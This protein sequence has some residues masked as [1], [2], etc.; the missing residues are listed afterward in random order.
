VSQAILL[1]GYVVCRAARIRGRSFAETFLTIIAVSALANFALMSAVTVLGLGITAAAPWLIV[2]ELSFIIVDV[3][4][5]RRRPTQRS[6]TAARDEVTGQP[7]PMLVALVIAGA[8]CAAIMLLV[9]LRRYGAVFSEWD[10][11]FSWNEWAL[12]WWSGR[13]PDITWMYPQLVPTNWSF[14]YAILGSTEL[15]SLPMAM[16]GLYPA[17]SVLMLLETAARRRLPTYAI[18]AA[19]FGVL[20]LLG[21]RGNMFSFGLELEAGFFALGAFCSLP[22]TDAPLAPSE[23]RAYLTPL[24]FAAAS[25]CTKQSGLLVLLAICAIAIG[26]AIRR[27][28][29][30]G[31]RSTAA[32]IGGTLAVPTLVAVAAYLPGY[33]TMPSGGVAATSYSGIQGAMENAGLAERFQHAAQVV[34]TNQPWLFLLA[35]MIVVAIIRRRSVLIGV[36]VVLP[37]MI[38]WAATLSYDFRN[39]AFVLPL[40]SVVAASAL[41]GRGAHSPV[42]VSASEDRETSLIGPAEYAWWLVRLMGYAVVAVPSALLVFAV[43]FIAANGG[44]LDRLEADQLARQSQIGSPRLNAALDRVIGDRAANST[45]L[46]DY[47]YML[48]LPRYRSDA[49]RTRLTVGTSIAYA[50]ARDMTLGDLEQRPDYV[51]LSESVTVPVEREFQRLMQSGDYRLL[52]SFPAEVEAG[53]GNTL[54]RVAERSDRTA[55]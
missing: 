32:V 17:A 51:V 42:F 27:A 49:R 53:L 34:A 38:F 7:S 43:A 41:L 24:L 9:A 23:A 1:P 29:L 31:A 11:V 44:S 28:R 25:A 55:D 15:Q 21:S 5:H 14:T 2:A 36:T 47:G 16:M 6:I 12:D 37:W 30:T 26:S 45:I 52:G 33:L 22:D 35:A 20:V 46:T 10:P 50:V 18:A 48:H 8:G 40:A 3:I 19:I 4:W 39:L 54:V 13:L